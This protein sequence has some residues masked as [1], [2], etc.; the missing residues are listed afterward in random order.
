MKKTI[1]RVI[2]ILLFLALIAAGTFVYAQVERLDDLKAQADV[3]L[4]EQQYDEAIPACAKLLEKTPIS[5]IHR[6]KAY[7]EQGMAGVTTAVDALLETLEGA[8]YLTEN[9]VVDRVLSQANNPAIPDSF[10]KLL[11]DRVEQGEAML[12]AEAER[13]RQEQAAREAAAK[14]EAERRQA[15]L[16]D[17][18]QARAEGRLEEAVKLVKESGLQ[19]ELIAEIEAQIVREHDEGVAAEARAALDALHLPEALAL[20]VQATDESVRDALTQEINDGWAQKGPQLREKYT[21]KLWA[22]AWY[23]LALGDEA[24]LTGDKRY[25][26]LE[27]GLAPEDTLVGGMFGWMK[28]SGG[29]VTL[30]GDTLGAEQ[31]AAEITD[32]VG[33][34][35]GWN[36]GLILHSDGTV[37]NLGNW[38]YGRKA[39]AE[40][41]GIEAVAAG[42]FHSLGLTKEGTVVAAGLDLDGQCQ[43]TEWTDVAAV[44]AGLR[45][46]VALTKDG[47][48]LAVGD[49]S[50]GQCDVGSW[51]DIVQIRCGGNFTLGL[52]ADGRLL[53]AGDNGCGQCDV[54]NWKDVVAFDGGL[55]HT[56][57][58]LQDGQVV[59][60]GTD[61]HGQCALQGTKLFETGREEAFTSTF[62]QQE[63]EYVYEADPFNGPWLYYG[64]DGSVIVSFDEDTGKIKATR[65]DLICTYGHPPV[66]ILSG[67]GDDKPRSAVKASILARQNRAV[68]ALTGDYYTFGY[69]ADGLQIRRGRVHKEKKDEV[70][71]GFYP[72]GSMRIID[73]H[74]VTAEELLSQGVN[75]SWVFG[76]ALIEN[77]EALDIHKHPLAKNDVTMRSVMASICP[78]HHVGAAYGFSTLNQVVEDLLSYGCTIAYNLDGGRSSMLVFMGTS[79]NKTVFLLEGWRGLQDMVGFLTSDLVPDPKAK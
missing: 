19:P 17:A 47:H 5:F 35:L 27:A 18:L 70:G 6:D 77:G 24:H 31:T 72:D 9:Q 49:N 76:P 28:I 65:A 7:V 78:Y 62:T 68:F 45:H 39:V 53:A 29:K 54:K 38:T 59:T 55:W 40:W 61:N 1:L 34:A 2:L 48:V 57:A 16:D 22:G 58:L 56:A 74:E 23:T 30:I 46:S 75:D 14:A 69:N 79:I 73:P 33:G 43:V 20:A 26:G 63:T 12:E 64:G 71:F 10:R 36:H 50:F 8:R 25:E 32:A 60:A 13:L 37:T 52:T 41:T 15:L 42:G 44:A 3:L 66:G 4:Q 51:K 21:N 67:G 11:Q